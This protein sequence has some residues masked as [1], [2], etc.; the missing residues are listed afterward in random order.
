MK[1]MPVRAPFS[2]CKS[3]LKKQASLWLLRLYLLCWRFHPDI[4]YFLL[5]L[6]G[7]G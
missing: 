3:D 4:R 6:Q 2:S 1:K 7:H 5:W